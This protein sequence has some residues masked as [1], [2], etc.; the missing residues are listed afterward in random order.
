MPDYEL[1]MKQ[2]NEKEA[3]RV[4]SDKISQLF[5][6]GAD[7]SLVRHVKPPCFPKILCF[8]FF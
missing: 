5:W 1:L 4:W 7:L 6:R 2:M 8:P 3:Q